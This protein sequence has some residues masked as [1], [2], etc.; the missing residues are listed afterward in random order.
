MTSA[1]ATL[2]LEQFPFAAQKGGIRL[3]TIHVSLK[4]PFVIL[5]SAKDQK[6]PP[7][8]RGVFDETRYRLTFDL[9]TDDYPT[10][11]DGWACGGVTISVTYAGT[12]NDEALSE[13]A[14]Q[15]LNRYLGV[16]RYE[17]GQLQVH[18]LNE[19]QFRLSCHHRK[20]EEGR[21]GTPMIRLAKCS[22]APMLPIPGYENPS[23]PRKDVGPLNRSEYWAYEARD[24]RKAVN[25]REATQL[26][27]QLLCDAYGFL[28]TD[29]IRH[30]VL[31]AAIAAEVVI[32]SYI[33]KKGGPL[34]ELI[35]EQHNLGF[36]IHEFFSSVLSRVKGE[37]S[38]QE[39][40][41]DRYKTLRNLFETR[42]QIAHT[43]MCRF[44]KGKAWQNVDS[45]KAIQFLEA[46]EFV[47]E[48][49]A[50]IR[51]AKRPSVLKLT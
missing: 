38:L 16:I 34:G 28:E 43:G 3:R 11:D 31:E 5:V 23:H 46:V 48:K 21:N 8:L 36:P 50:G 29:D 14:R 41:E 18:P 12:P 22:G 25:K 20:G 39:S 44:R 15:I 2:V 7:S 45:Q 13:R 9:P 6:K 19:L 24:V 1:H 32:K 26:A 17:T 33:G 42:N 10:F 47:A 49:F 51:L 40:E 35:V 27:E 4:M 30:A 37:Q